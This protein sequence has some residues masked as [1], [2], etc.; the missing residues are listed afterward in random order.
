MV[1]QAQ[2]LELEVNLTGLEP[3]RIDRYLTSRLAGFSR[4]RIHKLIENGL[5]IHAGSPVKASLKLFGGEKLT[6]TIPENRCLE[7]AAEEIPIEVIFEDNYLLVVNKPSGMVTH[8]G[9]GVS[10]GTLVNALLHHCQD[11]LSGICGTT[12]PGIVHRLDKDTSGL[13]VVAKED[14]AH[15]GLAE[16][17]R[18]RKARRTYIALVEGVVRQDTGCVDKPIGRHPQ[19]RKQMSV[20]KKGRPAISHYT[21]LQRWKKY[22]LVRVCL[23][24]GRTHQIRVHMASL[25]YPVVGD[26]VYNHK[27]TGTL[28]Q[29]HKLGLSGHALH[30]YQL[31]FIHPITG[32]L[33]EFEVKLPD[34][35]QR[36]IGSL[37]EGKCSFAI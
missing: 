20:Q 27:H 22:T 23:E 21:V 3:V 25:G 5:V 36:L 1:D 12:R 9:A 14:R 6:V 7:L 34:D 17:I 31:S 28:A 16:Q 37:E 10:D 13:M 19:L 4:S 15:L 33:L 32:I 30:A 2:T 29:R 11:S 26:I 8:P 24:T 18:A 35:F